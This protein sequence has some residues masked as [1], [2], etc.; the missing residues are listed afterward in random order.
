MERENSA[1]AELL[2]RGLEQLGIGLDDHARRRLLLYCEELRKWNRKINLIARNTSLPDIIEKHFLDSL[3]LLPVLGEVA[4]GSGPL[5]DVGSG[6]GFPG[7]VV[8]IAGPARR[9]L[10]LE[11]RQRRSVFLRHIIRTLSLEGIEVSTARV[12]DDDTRHGCEYF[13]VITGRAVADVAG[14]LEMVAPRVGPATIVAC[15]QGPTGKQGWRQGSL[16]GGLR[17]LGWR[18]I[19]LPFSGSRRFILLFQAIH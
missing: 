15:M 7:L 11:P 14:F 10:L 5:L 16:A 9:V 1:A 8:K 19:V 2:D 4:P 18:E 17:C 12:E 13:S 3:T 6:A